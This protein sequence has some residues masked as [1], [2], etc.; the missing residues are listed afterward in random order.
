MPA[1][2]CKCGNRLSL[3]EVPNPT[4]WL[5]IS[6]V[7]Y[8]EFQDEI[9]A[10]ELYMRFKPLIICPY[11]KRLICFWNGFKEDPIFYKIDNDND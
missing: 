10:E 6:D 11:C 1:I 3:G 2:L 7:E 4:E 5:L 9:D 8:D